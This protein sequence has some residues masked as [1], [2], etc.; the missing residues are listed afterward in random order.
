MKGRKE[1]RKQVEEKK[2]KDQTKVMK[3]KV[4]N[5]SRLKKVSRS[6]SNGGLNDLENFGVSG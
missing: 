2:H 6:G 5:D 4:K 3:R 1:G